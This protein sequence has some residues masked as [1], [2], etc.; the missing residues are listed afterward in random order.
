M[1]LSVGWVHTYNG[2]ESE[3]IP[4]ATSSLPTLDEARATQHGPDLMVSQHTP[5]APRARLH[6]AMRTRETVTIR[7]ADRGRSQR[8]QTFVKVSAQPI[9]ATEQRQVVNEEWLVQHM[10]NLDRPWLAEL[11]KGQQEHLEVVKRKEESGMEKFEVSV[12]DESSTDR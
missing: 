8:W 3:I 4:G 7:D 2:D 5:T 9:N 1:P 10:P 12:V 11:E 6:D